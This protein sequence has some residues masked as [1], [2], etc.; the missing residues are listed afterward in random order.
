LIV[1]AA[2]CGATACGRTELDIVPD[3]GGAGPGGAGGA[4]GRGGAGG[5]T[6]SG[7]QTPVPV[8]CGQGSCVPGTQICCIQ[9]NTQTCIPAQAPCAGASFSC[10]D[11]AACGGGNF[12]CLSLT[13]GSTSCTTQQLCGPAA[14]VFL[15]ASDAHCPSTAPRCCR[16]GATGVC[17]TQSCP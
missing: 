5:V 2:A 4:A 7:G 12:C 11:G 6:G 1:T 3:D 13:G 9:G 15:C 16:V 17:S 14:G 8:P 10:L